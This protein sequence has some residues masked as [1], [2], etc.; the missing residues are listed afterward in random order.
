MTS[1]VLVHTGLC[2][3]KTLLKLCFVFVV[4]SCNCGKDYWRCLEIFSGFCSGWPRDKNVRNGV[5]VDVAQGLSN[6][7]HFSVD[8]LCSNVIGCYT[9]GLPQ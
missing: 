2:L 4:Y 1:F 5:C 8:R 9:N 3:L 7:E 6:L